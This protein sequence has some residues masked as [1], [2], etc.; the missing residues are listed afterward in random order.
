MALLQ[1]SFNVNL[2]ASDENVVADAMSRFVGVINEQW[3]PQVNLVEGIARG[4]LEV[5]LHVAKERVSLNEWYQL[6]TPGRRRI[7][8]FLDP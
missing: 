5:P 4:Q 6:L 3:T 8:G 7:Y 1:Y 2:V